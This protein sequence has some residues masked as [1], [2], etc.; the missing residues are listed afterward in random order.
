ML[1]LLLVYIAASSGHT[2]HPNTHT[3]TFATEEECAAGADLMRAL[4]SPA[5]GDLT[6]TGLVLLCVPIRPT[7]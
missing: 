4:T 1:W 2:G 5:S 6:R 7:P 3:A